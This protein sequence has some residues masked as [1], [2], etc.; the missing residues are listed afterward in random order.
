MG[1]S[2]TSLEH[3]R[4][5][6][7][8]IFFFRKQV[9]YA[10]N[11]LFGSTELNDAFFGTWIARFSSKN[12]DKIDTSRDGRH[13]IVQIDP[14]DGLIFKNANK[15]IGCDRWQINDSE[16]FSVK[17][18]NGSKGWSHNV[19]LLRREKGVMKIVFGS[20][21]LSAPW[22]EYVD[23]SD[24]LSARAQEEARKRLEEEKR[25]LE[26]LETKREAERRREEEQKAMFDAM[27]LASTTKL[28][29][30]DEE[31]EHQEKVTAF[32]L[33]EEDENEKKENQVCNHF[34]K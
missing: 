29:D 32:T 33:M 22:I 26:E 5:T 9:E 4:I 11:R 21:D 20:N 28:P 14:V 16:S 2:L 34:N 13:E 7:T 17:P 6:H 10:P 3:Y 18:L 31:E 1:T 19:T 8:N 12:S 15:I 25:R 24:T 23:A 27:H 30:E